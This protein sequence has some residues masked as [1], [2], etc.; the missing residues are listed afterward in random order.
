MVGILSLEPK[1]PG[2]S[3]YL[4][5]DQ[6]AGNLC[7]D[8]QP[9]NILWLQN[10]NNLPQRQQNQMRPN[11]QDGRTPG[12]GGSSINRWL[13]IIVMV[14]L[15]IYAYSYFNSGNTSSSSQR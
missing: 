10:N 2:T 12:G 15:A 8:K 7:M 4:S 1:E 13:L 5:K 14:M 3:L 11:G 6:K 9:T